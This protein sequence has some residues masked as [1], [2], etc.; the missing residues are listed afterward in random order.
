[1]YL[2]VIV[3]DLVRL[4]FTPLIQH[5]LDDFVK[6][7]NQ[8]RIRK[9]RNREFDG[10]VPNDMYCLPR[11]FGTITEYQRDTHV[12]GILILL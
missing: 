8:H 12:T 10:G 7:W 2:F 11:R 5:D 1:M 4:I 3:R 6:S 9:Q